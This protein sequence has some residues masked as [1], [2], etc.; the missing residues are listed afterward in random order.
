MR[1]GD[2]MSRIT[3]LFERNHN[4]NKKSLIPFLTADYPTQTECLALMVAMA[5]AGADII[6]LGMPFSDPIADGGVIQEAS[7]W[8]LD[9]Y[10]TSLE[11]VLSLVSQFRETN[12]TPV[13]LMGY[14]NPIEQF[15]YERFCQAARHAGVD[16][17]L[18]VD[19]PPEESSSWVNYTSDVGL[20]PIFLIAPTTP[21]DRIDVITKHASGYIY[22]VAFKGVTGADKLDLDAVTDRVRHLK[23]RC[24]LPLAVGFGIKDAHS[25]KAVAEAADAVIIG[26]ELIRLIQAAT[27]KGDNAVKTVGDYLRTIRKSIDELAG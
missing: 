9:N 14:L 23:A 6:E 5:D 26:S 4:N 15:G 12:D 11:D 3:Q 1:F 22:S 24:T 20:D 2:T 7:Q 8:V 27:S 18:I 16:G 13:V 19:L 10:K 21:D 17:V 25:A